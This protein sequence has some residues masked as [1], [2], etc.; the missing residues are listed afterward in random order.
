M[1][2]LSE[3]QRAAVLEAARRPGATRNG[4]ARETGVSEGSVTAICSAAGISFD[5]SLTAAAVQ[6]RVIDLRAARVG[7]ATSVLDDVQ[8]ARQRMHGAEDNRAFLD[9]AK[10]VAALAGTHVRLVAFD[11]DDSSDTEAAKSMLGK[12]AQAL[13]VAAGEDAG[14]VVGDGAV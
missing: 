7:L 12:L 9:G 2:S 13:N 14:E 5:R 4:V 11:K 1:A 10:A 8:L 6:A 3:Q